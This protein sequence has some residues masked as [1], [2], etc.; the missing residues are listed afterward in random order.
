LIRLTSWSSDA[1]MPGPSSARAAVLVL[2]LILLT[3]FASTPRIDLHLVQKTHN[4][5]L[6]V[7]ALRQV[8]HAQAA[9][10]VECGKG[11]YATSLMDLS[12]PP[13]DKREA[14]LS[15]RKG[16]L[17]WTLTAPVRGYFF[18][19]LPGR[20]TTA[21]M[22]DCND[23]PTQTRY[24]V[25]AV[26]IVQGITGDRSFATNQDGTVWASKGLPPPSEPFAPPDQIVR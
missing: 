26:P 13:P 15:W 12:T 17:G 7:A 21:E 8:N 11:H 25:I 19:V 14:Y 20:G 9:Y 16:E 24:R 6:A 22:N 23:F 10:A 3:A 18:T 5:Q 4:E 1:S 2:S